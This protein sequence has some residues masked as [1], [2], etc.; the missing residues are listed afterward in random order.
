MFKKLV[1]IIIGIIVQTTFEGLVLAPN[2]CGYNLWVEVCQIRVVLLDV[3]SSSFCLLC[4]HGGHAKHM[5]DWFA[6]Y[7]HCP[8]GCGCCCLEASGW[9]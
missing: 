4:G 8:A 1:T 6:K 5:M 2:L 3:G 9:G 7:S